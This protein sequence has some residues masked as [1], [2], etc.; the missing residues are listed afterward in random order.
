MVA[1]SLVDDGVLFEHE[2]KWDTGSN[3]DS[4]LVIRETPRWKVRDN[5]AKIKLHKH[6]KALEHELTTAHYNEYFDYEVT[7]TPKPPQ[8][9]G[10]LA[11]IARTYEV[12]G[13]WFC[14]AFH[15]IPDYTPGDTFITCVCGRKYAVPFA[16]QSKIPYDV[17][18]QEPF[19]MPTERTIQP[20]VRGAHAR[21][22]DNA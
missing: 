14:Q 2:E 10:T 11:S 15:R 12:F 8:K 18:I 1:P 7:P 22:I 17:Y 21:L 3:I 20:E 5:W 4:H 9:T 13:V 19:Q 16:D 6:T